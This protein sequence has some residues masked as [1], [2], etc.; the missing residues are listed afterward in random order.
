MACNFKLKPQSNIS[1]ITEF[2]KEILS[3]FYFAFELI[4]TIEILAASGW[5]TEYNC[6]FNFDA[7]GTVVKYNEFNEV[8]QKISLVRTFPSVVDGLPVSQ[9]LLAKSM[10]LTN[11][12]NFYFNG[13]KVIWFAISNLNSV[14]AYTGGDI[15]PMVIP[16]VNKNSTSIAVYNEMIFVINY[17]DVIDVYDNNYNLINYVF[18]YT[19]VPSSYTPITIINIYGYLFIT[20]IKVPDDPY[21]PISYDDAYLNIYDGNT[22][23]YQLFTDGVYN[24]L[25]TS[26]SLSMPLPSITTFTDISDEF[27]NVP[28]STTNII[29]IAGG[30]GGCGG[31]S[32]ANIA[33]GGG[34]GAGSGF[35]SVNEYTT[36]NSTIQFKI[37]QGMELATRINPVLGTTYLINIDDNVEPIALA[38]PAKMDLME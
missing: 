33:D 10:V 36:F 38:S 21:I 27:F 28:A 29:I 22:F 14:H 1:S 8:L 9:R 31:V 37:G 2:T 7:C 30:G 12:E 34:G 11:D 24:G 26:L 23:I 25:L 35:I 17:N 18:P 4:P 15:A 20:F 6:Y 5:S 19:D 32:T 3:L 16:P 13:K